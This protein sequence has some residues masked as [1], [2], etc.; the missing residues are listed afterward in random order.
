MTHLQASLIKGTSELKRL[1]QGHWLNQTIMPPDTRTDIIIGT[2]AEGLLLHDDSLLPLWKDFA[3]AL[4]PLATHEH[5]ILRLTMRN[6][7]L[8]IAVLKPALKT[9]PLQRL[10]L[11]NNGLGCAGIEFVEHLLEADTTIEVLSL[12]KNK[13]EFANNSLSLAEAASKHTR[14][15]LSD[16]EYM[17]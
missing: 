17:D 3:E 1:N 2:D 11:M 12:N 7:Q 10:L 15:Q 5:G 9:A 4:C 16:L 13:I 14:L 8:P 6:V